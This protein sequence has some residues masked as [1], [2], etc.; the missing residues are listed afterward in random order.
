M[1]LVSRLVFQF[2]IISRFQF[3]HLG[4]QIR[5]CRR[6]STG[7]QLLQMLLG[8]RIVFLGCS[9]IGLGL[10]Y[11]FLG[12][13]AYFVQVS[14]LSIQLLVLGDGS[15]GTGY[16]AGGRT[17]LGR[18]GAALGIFQ[19]GLGSGQVRSSFFN[20]G[21]LTL[22]YSVVNPSFAIQTPW[23]ANPFYTDAQIENAIGGFGADT[24]NGT[25]L[26]NK[27]FGAAGNDDTPLR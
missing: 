2:G 18:T 26:A 10:V 20:T 13:T 9:Q 23:S 16:G 1:H 3:L 12:D 24:L 7:L 4:F 14:Q 17:N 8:S 21:I 11:F 27:I 19:L 15:F 22:G 5:N 6:R 25:A